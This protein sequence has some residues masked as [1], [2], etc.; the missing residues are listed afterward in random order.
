MN[1]S[2]AV[3]EKGSSLFAQIDVTTG[4]E[5]LITGGKTEINCYPNPFSNE[6]TIEFKLFEDSKVEVMVLN[7]MGQQVKLL[8]TEKLFNNGVHQLT[9]DGKNG[10]N[11]QVSS[12]IYY[13]KII[14]GGEIYFKK[15]VYSKSDN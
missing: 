15:I 5:G 8:T 14:L 2:K 7:Q 10:S 12:G 6:I 3:F 9:W 4:I 11:Q 1:N 13:V